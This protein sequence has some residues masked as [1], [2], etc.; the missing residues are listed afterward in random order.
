[1]NQITTCPRCSSQLRVPEGIT[2]KTINCPQCLAIVDNPHPG[3]PIQVADLNTDVKRDVKGGCIALAVL[4]GLCV[5]GILMATRVAYLVYFGV[6][7]VL[8]LSAIIRL[9]WKGT[10]GT[11]VSTAGR[12][13]SVLFIVL[14]TI[15]AIVIF[16]YVACAIAI[17]N[18]QFGK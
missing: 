10:S 8:V 4:I 3:T 2:W 16:V 12:V 15:V 1:M 17:S 7:P 6:I 11:A 9:A 14:G 13:V 18:M 5:C